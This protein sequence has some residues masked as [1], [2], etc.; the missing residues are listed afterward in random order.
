[1][2]VP[3]IKIVAADERYARLVVEPLES[4]MGTTI[5]NSLRRVLLSS[6][7]SAAV[8]WVKINEVPHE[9]SPIPLVKEDTI[10]FL[11]NV[12]ELKLKPLSDRPGK[13][14][15]EVSGRGVV[16]AAD[17]KPSADFE[18]SNPE[19]Y[20]ATLDSPDAT[21]TVE[22]NVEHGKGYVPSTVE[23]GLPIGIIPVDA[24]F[25]PVN[26][27]NYRV[28]NTRVEQRT[29]Y[30]RLIL[31]VW[32]N[33]TISPMEAITQSAQILVGQ[34]SIFR[35]LGPGVGKGL[36][37]QAL[38]G[39]GLHAENLDIPID[40]LNLSVR[41]YN[42]L[43]RH[44]LTRVVDVMSKTPD[45]LMQIRNFGEKSMQELRERLAE[46]GLPAFKEEGVEQP[47]AEGD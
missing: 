10:E 38:L 18:I 20:L 25:T 3:E 2:V 40:E 33:G 39:S 44:N 47:V 34:L 42:A 6:L 5:G 26:K 12:K 4:G 7:P 8:T 11:L 30:D 32:T 27:V 14:Y 35:S 31:E 23:E 9:F 24:I 22:F 43:K 46:F 19:H 37:R 28:E 29:N 45:E 17:I 1:M 41:A 15:L 13:L 36:G 21:L 16:T